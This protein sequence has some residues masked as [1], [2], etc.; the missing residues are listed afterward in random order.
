MRSRFSAFALGLEDYLLASWASATRPNAEEFALDDGL[1]WRR[2]LIRDT[3]A[4]GPDEATGYV[5][6]TAIARGPQGRIE[7]RE[8]SRFARD[9]RGRWV[10]VDGIED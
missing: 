8:R 6:F 1:E 2:L 7:L 9:D 5:A 10:Y 4:G 3:S